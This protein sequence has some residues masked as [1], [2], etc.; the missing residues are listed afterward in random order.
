PPIIIATT[1]WPLLAESLE[2]EAVPPISRRRFPN[3]DFRVSLTPQ[4]PQSVRGLPTL[5][6]RRDATSQQAFAFYRSGK[7][8]ARQVGSRVRRHSSSRDELRLYSSGALS[9]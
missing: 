7:H 9:G 4:Y 5:G 6:H 3:L 2:L 8:A 1:V